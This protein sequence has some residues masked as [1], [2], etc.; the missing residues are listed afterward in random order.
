VGNAF[1]EATI[2]L[3]DD[4]EQLAPDGP[5]KA[6][7]RIGTASASALLGRTAD[8]RRMLAS[9]GGAS[10]DSMPLSERYYVLTRM[11]HTSA[12]AGDT[13]QTTALVAKYRALP[14]DPVAVDHAISLVFI[15]N[16]LGHTDSASIALLE[17]LRV[18]ETRRGRLDAFLPL[19]LE[20]RLAPGLE[21]LREDPRVAKALG[22]RDSDTKA[23]QRAVPPDKP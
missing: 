4:I 11:L 23:P 20:F 8:A 16:A 7:V 12:L 6:L 3:A 18:D 13:A 17:A 15:G 19:A 10:L 9:V 1:A 5:A 14:R 22:L 2:R 21:A